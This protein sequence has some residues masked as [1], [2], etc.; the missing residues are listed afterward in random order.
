MVNETQ[1]PKT[2]DFINI[3]LHPLKHNGVPAL[4]LRKLITFCPANKKLWEKIIAASFLDEKTTIIATVSI[5]F[6][7]KVR[8][9]SKL[10]EM[11]IEIKIPVK[12]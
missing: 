10:K 12:K 1:I 2:N 11:G 4:E 8:A 9:L 7:D 5:Q 6:R 3:S